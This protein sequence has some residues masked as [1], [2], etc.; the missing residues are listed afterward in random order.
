MTGSGSCRNSCGRKSSDCY[1]DNVCKGFKD[2]CY[3]YN[4]YCKS[5]Q[6]YAQ[7]Y[8]LKTLKLS[9]C[10]PI[11]SKVSTTRKSSCVNSRGI[12]TAAYQV[13]HV[14]SYPGG[15]PLLGY[16]LVDLAGVP[17][18][19]DLDVVP[20]VWTWPGYTSVWTCPGHPLHQ[21]MGVSPI[22]T[23]LGYPPSDL[24]RVPPHL[25]LARVTPLGVDRLKTLPFPIHRMRSV[26]MYFYSDEMTPV[27]G[28]NGHDFSLILQV[29]TTKDW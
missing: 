20:P 5:W 29:R 18:Q 6:S 2:C 3:D 24:A 17:P 21:G 15:Y 26:N 19:S 28:C 13:L 7:S 14:L 10:N 23:W 8:Y 4:Q 1:C 9:N 27:W 11:Q 22:W 25:Y 12:R 16:P